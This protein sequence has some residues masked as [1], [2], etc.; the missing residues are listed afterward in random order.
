V[1]KTVWEEPALSLTLRALK[2][3]EPG[4]ER[5]VYQKEKRPKPTTPGLTGFTR[6]K[7]PRAE[8]CTAFGKTQRGMWGGKASGSSL[9]RRTKR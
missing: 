6:G 5:S 9:R 8:I 3:T 1:A 7:L 2:K 4:K